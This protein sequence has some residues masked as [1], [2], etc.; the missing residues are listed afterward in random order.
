MKRPLPYIE[1]YCRPDAKIRVGVDLESW[2]ELRW[3]AGRYA[4]ANQ[5]IRPTRPTGLQYRCTI[6]GYT[7]YVEPTWP[8][9]VGAT[10]ADGAATWTAETVDTNSLEST[11][12][13]APTWTAPSGAAVSGV[14]SSGQK[15]TAIADMTGAIAGQDYAFK[16]AFLLLDGQDPIGTIVMKVRDPPV[17]CT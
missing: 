12:N 3:T 2:L 14:S 10:V 7:G 11:V 5:R 13:G 8:T 9:T 15:S 4:A 16:C 6:A 17:E 1:I